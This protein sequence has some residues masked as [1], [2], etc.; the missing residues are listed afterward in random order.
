MLEHLPDLEMVASVAGDATSTDLDEAVNRT[1]K[2]LDAH[3]SWHICT[4][5][6]AFE[7]ISK[8]I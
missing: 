2:E 6:K 5:I 7:R 1:V 3:D 8:V 4:S